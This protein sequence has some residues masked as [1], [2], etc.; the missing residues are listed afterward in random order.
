MKY[1]LT[2]VLSLFFYV[3]AHAELRAEKMVASS[4]CMKENITI[5]INYNLKGKSFDEIKKK[6]DEQNAKIEAYAKE[7]KLTKFALQNKNY[8]IS[9]SASSYNQGGEPDTFQYS[10]NGNVSY[11]LENAEAAFKFCE[12]LISQKIQVSMNSNMYNQ[13]NCVNSER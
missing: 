9:A 6:F 12:F 1:F 11:M 13:G 7:Q 3:S 10:G 8:N 5:N 4:E 2:I